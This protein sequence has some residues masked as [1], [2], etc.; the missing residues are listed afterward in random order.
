LCSD[1]VLV[2]RDVGVVQGFCIH[3]YTE[4]VQ[5]YSSDKW[6]SSI[7]ASQVYRDTGVVQVYRCIGE[8]HLCNGCRKSTGD[9]VSSSTGV[10]QAYSFS[11]VLVV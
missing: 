3:R 1:V 4:S 5:R 8:V 9:Q 10:V 6:Y 11:T 2:Y 7:G